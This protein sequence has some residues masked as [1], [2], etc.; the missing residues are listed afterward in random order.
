[1][2]PNATLKQPPLEERSAA[3]S[4]APA[5]PPAKSAQGRMLPALPD[6]LPI[7]PV[8][9]TVVFPGTIVPL[10]IGRPESIRLLEESLPQSR[11]VG[12]TSQR[13]ASQDHPRLDGLFRVGSACQVLKLVRQAEG[14]ALLIVNALQRFRIRRAV[15]T[16]PYLR[17]EID[18]LT[19]VAPPSITPAWEATVRGLRET[20]IQLIELT[21]NPPEELRAIVTNITDAGLLADFVANGLNI[22]AAQKQQLLEEIDVV[23]RVRAVHQHVS[24]QLEMAR[25]QQKLQQEVSSQFTDLQRRAYLREQIRAAQRELGEGEE[26][27]EAQVG[28]LRRQLAEAAPPPAVMEQAERELRR[29]NHIP[30]ASPEYSVI[31]SYVETVAELPWSRLTTDNLDLRRAQKILDRDHFNLAKVKRRLIEYLA[32]RKLNPGGRGAILCFLGPPGVGKTSLGQSIADALGRKFARMSLGG[33][34]DEAEIRGHRQ[35]LR[36]PP[37]QH[38]ALCAGARS[39]AQPLRPADARSPARGG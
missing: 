10:S 29:L 37:G 34:R 11:I 23:R 15:Q 24:A 2:N 20:A 7:L 3:A 4:E 39:A 18:T 9:N 33:M 26:G 32:V 12:V 35:S 19:P 14:S 28:Q 30:P 25:I 16:Q 27:V 17:A 31:V 36:R 21:P 5:S 8:R 6:V 38:H 22:D 13:D 1:M